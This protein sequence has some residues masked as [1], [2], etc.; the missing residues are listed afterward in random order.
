VRIRHYGAQAGSNRRI[1]DVSL[2]RAR[3]HGRNCSAEDYGETRNTR[4]P[5]GLPDASTSGSPALPAAATCLPASTLGCWWGE[6]RAPAPAG[7]ARLWRDGPCCGR[8]LLW[9]GGAGAG[10]AGARGARRLCCFRGV[11]RSRSGRG[12]SGCGV[13]SRQMAHQDRSFLL[14]P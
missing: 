8:A 4:P 2:H 13:S 7:E 14:G 10:A 3:N 1:M 9:V 5:H 11:F 12:L 6:Q